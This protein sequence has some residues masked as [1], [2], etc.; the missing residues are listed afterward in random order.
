MA[1]HGKR[2]SSGRG[3]TLKA[4]DRVHH[5]AHQRKV[6]RDRRHAADPHAARARKA[7]AKARGAG[8]TE[9]VF[10][11]NAVLEALRAQVPA[12]ALYL[13]QGVD[14]DDRVREIVEL[15]A[16][17]G[18]SLLQAQR[19]E[20]DAL[21]SGG[22]HQG[23]LLQVPPYRYASLDDLLDRAQAAKTA[24]LIVLLDAVTDPHNVGAVLRS[25]GAFGATGVVIPERRAAGVTATAWKVS[26]GAAARVPVAKVPNLARA[27]RELK[28]HGVF[29]VGLDG[30]GTAEVGQTGFET[31]PVA[32]VVGSEGRGI[33]RLVRE[34]C[35]AL[36][37][38]PISSEVESLNAAVAAGI[39][40]YAVAQARR[41]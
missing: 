12:S 25:A 16:A 35:D 17:R 21:A 19:P 31:D 28:S 14:S 37:A 6:D 27:V 24:P 8:V 39:A 4:E 15:A 23:V 34:E 9:T 10:G 30:R 33:Q 36:A 26:A 32:L 41:E 3:P 40:L 1:Q 11:R 38:I 18:V 2:R 5:V 13:A 20:L 29:V 7:A 22:V